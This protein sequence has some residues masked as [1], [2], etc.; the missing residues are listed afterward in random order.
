MSV[1]FAFVGFRHSHILGVYEAV[2]AREDCQ[3]AAACEEDPSTRQDLRDGGRVEITHERFEDLLDE[4]FDVLAVGDVYALRGGR[5]V[6]AMRRGKHVLSDK[7]LCTSLEELGG[8]ETL[9]HG[10]NLAVGL[11]LD[12]RA[13]GVMR[14]MRSAIREGRIGE[15]HTVTFTGQH[16]L[17]RTRRPAWYFQPGLH[18]GTINDIAVHGIDAVEWLTGRRIDVIVAA[19]AWNACCDA[20]HFQDG[21]QLMLRLDNQGGVL[22][23]VSYLAPEQFGYKAPQYWRITC[24]G[25]EGVVE[26]AIHADGVSL[27]SHEHQEPELLPPLDP[28]P[29]YYLDDLLREIRG[30]TPQE[31]ATAEVL[32]ASRITLEAQAMADASS[33]S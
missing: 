5:I 19:R 28:K 16:P 27:I 10:Q 7:P 15:V 17:L 14:A 26:S 32:R 12:L 6:Q 2:V 30:E 18:G 24:H 4:D 20:E 3:L 8:I 31:I 33:R 22:G 25:S 11:Q 21:A 23:D 29:L 13:S 9:S 1:R